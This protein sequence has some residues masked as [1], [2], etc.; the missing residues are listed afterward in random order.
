MRKL[1]E[2]VLEDSNLFALKTKIGKSSKHIS[3]LVVHAFAG[4][5]LE[6]GR[7]LLLL[8]PTFHIF[9]FPIRSELT[10][11]LLLVYS[12]ISYYPTRDA[13]PQQEQITENSK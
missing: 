7:L 13:P 11:L 1:K 12:T 2:L 9:L 6:L 4:L 10:S 3:F 8:L 5:L